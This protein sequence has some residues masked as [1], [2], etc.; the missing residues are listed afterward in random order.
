MAHFLKLFDSAGA[1]DFAKIRDLRIAASQYGLPTEAKQ[2]YALPAEAGITLELILFGKKV[3]KD[4][5]YEL[6]RKPPE[7]GPISV[8]TPSTLKQRNPDSKQRIERKYE[9]GILREETVRDENGFF[10]PV[11]SSFDEDA[12]SRRAAWAKTT[13]S[14]SNPEGFR[15]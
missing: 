9:R 14:I 1:E 3:V 15:R 11:T 6:T 5:E 12:A 10:D 7:A 4:K 2:R 8:L 13:T